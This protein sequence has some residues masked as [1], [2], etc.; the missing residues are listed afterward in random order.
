MSERLLCC[1]CDAGLANRMHA[2][3]GAR[4]IAEHTDRRLVVWWPLNEFIGA[5]FDQLFKVDSAVTYMEDAYSFADML[6]STRNRVKVYNCGVDATATDDWQRVCLTDPEEVVVIK[7]WYVP[8]FGGAGAP[9]DFWQRT[10][11]NLRQTFQFSDTLKDELAGRLSDINPYLL[12]AQGDLFGVHIR[13]GDRMA[14]TSAWDHQVVRRYE[15]SSAEAFIVAMEQ[16]LNA[17]P[18]ARFV[19]S[20]YNPDITKRLVDQFGSFRIYTAPPG[21]DRSTL[22]GIRNDAAEMFLLGMHT[23][24][25]IGSHYSQF[26][27]VA[28]EYYRRPLV[29]AGSEEMK[30]QIDKLL[31]EQST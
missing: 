13:Y 9:A 25:V 18:E 26:S 23:Q 24:F 29:I 2:I 15:K 8:R 11:H 17:R 7:S 14:G 21:L 27:Q 16:I 22:P 4:T 6:C 19:L 20:C 3:A 31:N 5:R 1:F 10:M 28:A 30:T 12:A